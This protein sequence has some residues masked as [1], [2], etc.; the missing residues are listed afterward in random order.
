[1]T[2]TQSAV[3]ALNARFV[4]S[5]STAK[6]RDAESGND[7][8]GARYYNP[9]AGRFMSRD[10]EDGIPTDP[11]SL[12]K[13]IY[14]GGDPVNAF[15]PSGRNTLTWPGAPPQAT[16]PTRSAIEYVAIVGT[17]S[18]GAVEGVKAVTCAINIANTVNALRTPTGSFAGITVNLPGCTAS[19]NCQPF[20]DA[21][22]R[23]YVFIATL[24]DIIASRGGIPLVEDG[25]LIGAIGCS[26][27]TGA[28]DEVVCTAGAATINK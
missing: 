4:A 1:M 23:G 2:M 20:E 11:V 15:D 7:Y 26:G 17:I 12:H 10:P 25:K 9:I 28:Q 14:A 5:H 13:Y 24:D 21:I 16:S 6:E 8:F 22:Q 19:K 3:C 27:A 18:L